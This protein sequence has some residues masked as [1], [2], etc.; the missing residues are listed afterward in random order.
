MAYSY[1]YSIATL[2]STG[3]KATNGRPIRPNHFNRLFKE[4]NALESAIGLNPQG[5]QADLKTR[6]TQYLNDDGTYKKE[7]VC[8]DDPSGNNRGSAR[9]I[10]LG[11][12]AGNTVKKTLIQLGGV[13]YL[14]TTMIPLPYTAFDDSPVTICC[15]RS[16]SAVLASYERLQILASQ[17]FVVTID[18]R[19]HAG[20][21][22]GGATLSID[23][24][25]MN[26]SQFIKTFQEDVAWC[27]PPA[28]TGG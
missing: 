4:V 7:L 22:F 17:P 26:I 3:D 16:T 11:A 20:A 18:C 14:A 6:L 12:W 13:T 5:S 28:R 25:V 23:F 15:I 19:G 9:Y 1:P 2:S 21:V 24:V 8:E 27:L 10:N